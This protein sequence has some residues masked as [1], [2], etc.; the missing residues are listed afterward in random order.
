MGGGWRRRLQNFMKVQ[1]TPLTYEQKI[2]PASLSL[3]GLPQPASS[4]L[5]LSSHPR[6]LAGAARTPRRNFSAASR[7]PSPGPQHVPDFLPCRIAAAAA[8]LPLTAESGGDSRGVDWWAPLLGRRRSERGRRQGFRAPAACS[9]AA[10]RAGVSTR[11]SLRTRSEWSLPPVRCSS[12]PCLRQQSLRSRHFI[13]WLRGHAEQ[14]FAGER[15]IMASG[16]EETTRSKRRRDEPGERELG[17]RCETSPQMLSDPK[18]G[19]APSFSSFLDVVEEHYMG[20]HGAR[21]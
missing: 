5:A 14:E 19:A 3:S 21:C 2:L 8:D 13:G 12:R 17:P 4:L 10:R 16:S 1:L 20:L 9:P 6:A 7:G 11:P 18:I 15:G